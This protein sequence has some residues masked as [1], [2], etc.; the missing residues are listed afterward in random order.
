MTTSSPSVCCLLGSSMDATLTREKKL[1]EEAK[2]IFL[3]SP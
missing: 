2:V 3:S 1:Y